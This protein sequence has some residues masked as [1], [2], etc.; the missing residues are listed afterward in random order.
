MSITKALTKVDKTPRSETIRLFMT[1]TPNITTEVSTMNIA[2][3]LLSLGKILQ[4]IKAIISV[5]PVEP[6]PR[7]VSAHPAPINE[8]PTIGASRRAISVFSLP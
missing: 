1:K 3:E 2:T 6:P 8:P 7:K 5:P 4:R